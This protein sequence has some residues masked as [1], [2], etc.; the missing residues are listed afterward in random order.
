MS[1]PLRILFVTDAFPPHAGGSG[2]STYFLARGL[3]A[4]GHEVRIVIA[5]PTLRMLGTHYDDFPVWRPVRP[6]RRVPEV[7]LH[8]TGLAAGH[9]TSR[10]V[11]DWQPDVLHAQHVLSAQVA[12]R[13]AGRT[14]MVI[15]VRDHWPTCFY[16]TALADQQ[17]PCCLSGTRSPCN[18][19]RGSPHAS[20][21]LHAAKAAVMRRTLAHRADVLHDAA[22]VIAVS[23]AI[24]SEIAPLIAPD[25]LH[26]IPNAFDES[27]IEHA[28]LPEDMKLPD[29]FFLYAGKLSPHKG[30]DILPALARALPPDAPP[31]VVVG[32]GELSDTLH[33]ADPS[34]T[35]ITL[36]GQVE[37]ATVLALM[38][39]ATAFFF[40]SR[41]AEP[42]SRTP[43]EAQMMG[44]P[45][46]ATATG[47]TAETVIDGETGFLTAPDDVAGMS[48]HLTALATDNALWQRMSTA[49]QQ[50][51]RATYAL[52]AIAKRIEAVYR[53]TVAERQ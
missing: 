43:I 40:P 1:D 17:C 48:A 24:E 2:W 31:L 23:H 4:R 28:R 37:N 36:L 5:A 38:A 22:A 19:R 47:G 15:T 32:D 20:R 51:T 33:A 8:T 14:P 13:V 52:P 10:L 21:T 35:R 41:W 50:R 34:G 26:V 30:A 16:G 18:L 12:T 25:R 9:T 29:R 39:R 49:A 6:I 27:V 45:V 42:L 11:R 46:V 3:R 53:A 44:C 7:A